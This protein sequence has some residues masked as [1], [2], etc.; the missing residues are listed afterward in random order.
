M[1]VIQDSYEQQW[2][3]RITNKELYGNLPPISKTLQTRRLQFSGHCWRGKNEIVS[4]MLHWD[5]THGKQ[6]RGCPAIT[7]IDQ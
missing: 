2:K 6:S 4:Q 3:A 7:F 1:A 5:P